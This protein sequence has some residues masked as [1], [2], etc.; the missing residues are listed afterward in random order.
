M[1][2]TRLVRRQI[3]DKDKILI[4]HAKRL[5]ELGRLRRSMEPVPLPHPIQRG[6][7]RSF[8]LRDDIARRRDAHNF[9]RILGEINQTVY[10]RDGSFKVRK[11]HNKQLEDVPHRLALISVHRWEK[12]NWPTSLKKWFTLKETNIA[13]GYRRYSYA[14]GYSFDYPYFFDTKTEPHFVTH[15]KP[16]NPNLEREEA[17]IEA[18]MDHHQGWRRLGKLHGGNKRGWDRLE[19]DKE[20]RKEYREALRLE[21]SEYEDNYLDAPTE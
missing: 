20:D 5:R 15:S 10:S 21:M 16:I 6:F 2:R 3:E 8:K 9:V 14:K 1:K 17:E 11:F 13:T 7:K 12:L 19:E 18:F 4:R